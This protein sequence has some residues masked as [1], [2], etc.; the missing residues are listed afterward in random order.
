MT[1][2]PHRVHASVSRA[3]EAAS[4][5]PSIALEH[6]L[7]YRLHRVNKLTDRDSTRA[8]LEVCGLPLGEGRALA[9]IGCFA[10]LSVN[11]LARAANLDKAQASRSAQA[12]VKRGLIRK[13]TSE[14]DG[15]GVVLTLTTA[16]AAMHRRVMALIERRNEEIFACLS[17]EEQ[18]QLGKWL[19][20]IS[21]RLTEM[22]HRPT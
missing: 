13:Q 10:P 15:R 16:G 19:D 20:R 12:L 21:E 3:D 1:L 4:R 11:D 9:A 2:D 14:T 22:P 6:F 7:T 5:C 18:V 8:Y 17:A